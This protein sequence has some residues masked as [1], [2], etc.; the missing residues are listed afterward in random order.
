M[1]PLDPSATSTPLPQKNDNAP[2]RLMTFNIAH[3]RGLWLYQGL[4]SRKTLLANLDKIA[5][6]I[7][8]HDPHIVALQ[9]IDEDSHWTKRINLFQQL[10][11]RINFPYGAMGSHNKKDH[12]KR[13]LAYGNAL[14]SQMPIVYSQVEA[15]GKAT[16]GEK[17]FLYAQIKINNI[18]LPIINLHLDYR[19][20]K[21]R[22]E[23]V[24]QIIAFLKHR[25]K[26][27]WPPIV[28][29]DFNSRAK[30]PHDAIMYLYRYLQ[31]QQRSTL[32][33]VGTG[34]FPS[35]L[36]RHFMSKTIDFI[37]MPNHYVVHNC[38]VLNT[39]LSDHRPILL[40]FS[41]P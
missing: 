26:S 4:R 29:G 2:L 27:D 7:L 6:L 37:I 24:E 39:Y 13:P 31:T 17:G 32:F 22:I 23:Q 21:R 8:K 30:V 11:E 20:R 38:D 5:T 41:L 34:T 15:F 19:S 10:K 40:E 1:K 18:L 12:P 9:E 35:F 25:P 28:C 3:G 33:P 16:L 14:L 36:P